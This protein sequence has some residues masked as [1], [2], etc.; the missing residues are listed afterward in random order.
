MTAWNIEL[1]TTLYV[2]HGGHTALPQDIQVHVGSDEFQAFVNEMTAQPIIAIDT[3]TTGLVRWK[4]IPLYW[5]VAWDGKRA[6]LNADVLPYFQHIFDDPTKIW[7]FANAKYDMH[8]LANVGIILRGKIMCTQVM[9]SLLY[10][11]KPHRLKFMAKHILKW[12][13]ADFQDSFGKIGKLQ[14][15]EDVLRRAER[16]NMPLLVEY[17]ANDAW[18]TYYIWDELKKQLDKAQTFS[19]FRDIHPYISTLWDLF[20]KVEVPYTKALWRMERKGAKVNRQLLENA[21]PPAAQEIKEIEQEIARHAGRVI[22]PNSPL[23]VRKYMFEER[24]LKPIKWSKGGKSGK[25]NPSADKTVLEHYKYDDPVVELILKHHEL[26]KLYGTYLIGLHSVLNP[27]T[28]RIHTSFN[29]DVARTG[30]LSSSDPNLQNIPKPEND[31]W[32]IRGA[33]ITDPGYTF[34]AIDYEQLEMRLL[35]CAS[36]EPTMIDIFRKNWDIHMGNAAMMYDVPYEDLKAAKGTD[37]AIKQGELGP[38][39]MTEYVLK[40]LQMRSDAKSIGFGLN[41]GMGAGKLGRQLGISYKESLAKIARYK[42]AYPAVTQFYAEAIEE[43]ARS[44]YA[45]TVLGRRRNIPEIASTR[46]DERAQGERLAVN[47][48]IQGSAADVCKMAQINLDKV[49]IS[50]RFG[51]DMNLQVHDE[52]GFECPTEMVQE[53]LPEIV[54]LMEHPFSKDLAVHLAVDV[55]MGPSWGTAK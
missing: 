32:G 25:R 41:Y 20:S 27:A 7:V 36:M 33:F 17:A 18:G 22:N 8:I 55:G 35:A 21:A 3:E 34:I 1:P 13:W 52:L 39:A 14:S 23:Q 46:K 30:R 11:D 12:S 19:L 48:Q 24:G 47:T 53:V 10:E 50:G 16:E 43:T 45:F 28:D 54:D 29:Q 38:E 26:S 40:C 2:S 42:D 44:G 6:T 37:K 49:D 4:D 31:K 51:C 9:H 15:A 5:S